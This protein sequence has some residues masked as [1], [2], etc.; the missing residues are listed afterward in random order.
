MTRDE[1]DALILELLQGGE[2]NTA[3]LRAH[4]PQ[5]QPKTRRTL[6]WRLLESM[7]MRGLILKRK[8]PVDLSGAQYAGNLWRIKP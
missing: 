3:A 2:Q 8:A 7:E 5:F 4:F 6:F 1:S